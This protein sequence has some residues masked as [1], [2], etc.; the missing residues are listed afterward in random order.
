M[1]ERS[2]LLEAR[3]HSDETLYMRQMYGRKVT[4]LTLRGLRRCPEQP[5]TSREVW[6]GVA[7]GFAR[8]HEVV[9]EVSRGR[10]SEGQ[11]HEGPNCS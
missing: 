10:S 6:N 2:R 3:S 9:V 1:G 5:G 4:R 8:V 11:L 7:S